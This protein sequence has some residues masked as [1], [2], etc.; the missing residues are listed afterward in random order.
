MPGI[1]DHDSFQTLVR[2]LREIPEPDAPEKWPTAQLKLLADAGG[3]R[4]NIACN[5][6]GEGID[7]EEMLQIYREL[8]GGSL[9][10]TFILTQRNAACQRIETSAN[11]AC[12]TRLL[13]ALCKGEL[14]ATVGISHLTTSRQHLQNAAVSVEELPNGQGFLLNGTVPWATGAMQADI[15]VTGG[16]LADGRQILA[17]IPRDRTGVFVRPPVALLGMSSS[18]TSQVDLR[19]VVVP[20]DNVLHGPVDRVMTASTGGGAGSLGTSAVAIGAAQGTLK[21]FAEEVD[22]RLELVEFFLPLEKSAKDLADQLKACASGRQ[23]TG[24]FSPESIRQRANS[25]VIRSAQSW[26]AATKGAGFVSGHPAERA[27]R[28]SLFFLVWS[29]PQLVLEGNLR[30]LACS[31]PESTTSIES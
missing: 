24:L 22:Q 11:S 17:A 29:C 14:F 15:L 23:T 2:T 28:E 27:V 10:T 18:Q 7:P 3:F 25:L 4:W 13:P 31:I 21:M 20:F 12:A 1:I 16:T 5:F 19:E 8:S 9:L 26:L 30:E 6:G